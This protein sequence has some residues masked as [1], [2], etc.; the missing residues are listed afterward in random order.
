ML[1]AEKEKPVGAKP[2]IKR[3]AIRTVTRDTHGQCVELWAPGAK[4]RLEKSWEGESWEDVCSGSIP[5]CREEFEK[6]AGFVL[7]PGTECRVAITIKKVQ[8]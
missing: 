2:R 1:N 6:L 3:S 4:P 5:V 8:E 7:E